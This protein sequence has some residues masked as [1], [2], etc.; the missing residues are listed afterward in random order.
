VGNIGVFGLGMFSSVSSQ[1]TTTTNTQVWKS[2]VGKTS[3][4]LGICGGGRSRC[5]I[6][7]K[8]VCV[9]TSIKGGSPGMTGK[10]WDPGCTR[11]QC[12]IF[13]GRVGRAAATQK[14]SRKRRMGWGPGS[15]L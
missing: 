10:I 4:G 12:D 7:P 1:K 9:S 6:L 11:G 14:K 3:A 8:K 5:Y 2:H 15:T 13:R